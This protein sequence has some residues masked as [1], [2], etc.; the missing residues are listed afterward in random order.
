MPTSRRFYRL[1]WSVIARIERFVIAKHQFRREY[2]QCHAIALLPLPR[3]NKA[4]VLPRLFVRVH[5]TFST[6]LNLCKDF[7]LHIGKGFVGSPRA[8][9][10]ILAGFDG[11]FH[12]LWCANR[13]DALAM[14]R[15][16]AVVF[17]EP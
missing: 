11:A 7:A 5:V 13:P 2:G 14:L 4:H 12:A 16:D 15:T 3:T 8:M 1:A 9:E 17:G 10:A 6:H